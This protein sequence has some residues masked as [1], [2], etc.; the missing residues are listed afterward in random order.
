MAGPDIYVTSTAIAHLCSRIDKELQ[1]ALAFVGDLC[2]ANH[3]DG[4][5]FG[6]AGGMILE[7]PY[8]ELRQ[9]AEKKMAEAEGC[10]ESWLTTLA[11][12]QRNWRAAEDASAVR[13]R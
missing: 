4:L 7:G 11:T 9:W 6:I 3:V 10:T 13:Y 12:A 2:E 8:E 1:G 5:G